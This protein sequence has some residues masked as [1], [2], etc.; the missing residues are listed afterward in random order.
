MAL[1]WVQE[2][3][4]QFG[5]DPKQVYSSY[6]TTYLVD[7]ILWPFPLKT[8]PT[9]VLYTVVAH[10]HGKVAKTVQEVYSATGCRDS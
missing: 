3:I 8:G 5:G 2:N 1:R 4:D 10:I 6:Y 7:K 9:F